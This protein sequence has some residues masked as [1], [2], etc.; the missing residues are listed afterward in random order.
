M[1]PTR[2]PYDGPTRKLTL[3]Q[4]TNV[5]YVYETVNQNSPLVQ[6]CHAIIRLSKIVMQ[7]G[8]AIPSSAPS[9]EEIRES[10]SA[11]QSLMVWLGVGRWGK[12]H[13]KISVLA[14]GAWYATEWWF[15]QRLASFI[16]E[17]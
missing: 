1:T 8:L 5:K 7:S 17:S 12:V 2:W 11:F 4:R 9:A 13:F 6:G 16:L 14:M 15:L 10:G 3:G